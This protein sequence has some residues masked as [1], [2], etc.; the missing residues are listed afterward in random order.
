MS[1]AGHI[2][3]VAF[4][5]LVQLCGQIRCTGSLVL[6]S[7]RTGKVIGSFSFENGELFDARMGE[8]EGREAVYRALELKEATFRVDPNVR[9]S[10]R[11]IF[12][13]IGALLLE[14]MRRAD[15]RTR[16]V[17]PVEIPGQ[18][19]DTMRNNL[20]PIGVPQPRARSEEQH[21]TF[22]WIVAMIVLVAA[23]AA[24]AVVY[25]RRS[26]AREQAGRTA[27]A[28]S[29]SPSGRALPG[30]PGGPAGI[31]DTE[32]LFGMVAPFTGPA[33][34]LGREMKIGVEAAFA[35][36]NDAGGVNGRRLRLITADD[37][38]EPARTAPAMKDL[39]D[40]QRVFAVVGNVGTP[41]AAVALPIA[42][43]HKMIFYGAFTGA[44]LLRRDP[45]DRYVFNFRASYAEETAAVVQYLVRTRRLRPEQIAVF[46]QQDAFGDAGFE[47]VMR[48]IRALRPDARPPLRVGYQRNTI[49]VAEAVE[50][51]RE[52]AGHVRVRAV[53]MVATYRAAAK[54]I[55]KMRDLSPNMIFT[56]V[57]F[58]GSTS[59]AEELNLLGSRYANGVIVTQ[60]VPQVEGYST[61]VLKY[62]TALGK[63]APGEKLDYVSLEGYWAAN[64]LIEALRRTGRQ[65]DTE[66]L[67][68]TLEKLRDLDLGIG[69]R[70]SYGLAEHQGSHK[71]WGTQLNA[72]GHYEVLD[73][74]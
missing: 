63:Y 15:E 53:V 66:A 50:H 54:F 72:S 67:V 65:L 74:D 40:R 42:L 10:E 32:V 29:I 21:K 48:A 70:I 14:G 30:A 51:L 4:S 34:E 25:K 41:T 45:P 26:N 62:K 36:V 39:C 56:N 18:R 71:V 6:T 9:S 58:V 11:R 22:R 57:S 52:H 55:E 1:L 35:E 68:D 7:P 46:A 17:T 59:L 61:A 8:T 49:D 27:P 38:Y 19:G 73:L 37:G 3:E 12:I 31:T 23:G 5:D 64:V 20:G 16:R 43:E 28:P 44:N 2:G 13:S 60:V 47:G 24:G 33:R 69:T